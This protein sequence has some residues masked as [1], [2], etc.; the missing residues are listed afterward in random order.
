PR[1]SAEQPQLS[2]LPV[3]RHHQRTDLEPRTQ[4]GAHRSLSSPQPHKIDRSRRQVGQLSPHS[5]ACGLI[6]QHHIQLQSYLTD[7]LLKLEMLWH[8]RGSMRKWP[9]MSSLWCTR[10]EQ[11]SR[12]TERMNRSCRQFD[13]FANLC[14]PNSKSKKLLFCSRTASPGELLKLAFCSGWISNELRL[15]IRG[16]FASLK[17]LAAWHTLL[18]ALFSIRS[19]RVAIGSSGVHRMSETRINELKSAETLMLVTVAKLTDLGTLKYSCWVMKSNRAAMPL[20]LSVTHMSGSTAKCGPSLAPV[21]CTNSAQPFTLSCATKRSRGESAGAHWETWPAASE[22]SS[23][24]TKMKPFFQFRSGGKLAEIPAGRCPIAKSMQHHILIEVMWHE[25]RTLLLL[26]AL[27]ACSGSS[28]RLAVVSEAGSLADSSI[29]TTAV[30]KL[31]NGN[32]R[33]PAF[34]TSPMS[35]ELLPTADSV[36]AAQRVCRSTGLNGLVVVGSCQFVSDVLKISGSLQL[37]TVA[38]LRGL[39]RLPSVPDSAI[40]SSP[41]ATDFLRATAEAMDRVSANLVAVLHD[42]QQASATALGEEN[43]QRDVSVR[44]EWA[45]NLTQILQNSVKAQIRYCVVVC[46]PDKIPLVFEQINYFWTV[47]DTGISPRTIETLIPA[48]ESANILLIRESTVLLKEMDCSVDLG[49]VYPDCQFSKRSM[50]ELK[51]L[52]AVLS[53]ARATQSLLDSSDLGLT[54]SNA[55]CRPL[56]PWS[57]GPAVAAQLKQPSQRKCG[58]HRSDY[59]LE[60][61][62]LLSN[63]DAVAELVP[64]GRFIVENGSLVVTFEYKE[65]ELLFPNT[66]VD[67]K[68][69]RLRVCA[70]PFPPFTRYSNYTFGTASGHSVDMVNYYASHLNFSYDIFSPPDIQFGAPVEGSPYFSGCI[71]MLQRGEAEFAMPFAITNIRYQVIDY[72]EDYMFSANTI[73]V[74]RP[75]SESKLWN[76]FTPLAW[77]SWLL[78]LGM[79]VFVPIIVFV[80]ASCNPFSGWNLRISYAFA[81]EV[82]LKEYIWSVIGSFLQQGQDFYPFA[83][84]PRTVLAFWWMLTVIL[85]G[86]YTGDL[87]AKLAVTVAEYPI[88]SLEDL[89]SM[90]HYKAMVARGT[91]IYATIMLATDGPMALLRR[92]MVVVDTMTTCAETLLIKDADPYMVCISDKSSNSFYASAFCS[93]VYQATSLFNYYYQ[94]MTFPRDAYYLPAFDLLLQRGKES[95]VV[96]VVTRKYVPQSNDCG[97]SNAAAQAAAISLEGVGG[98]YIICL[99]LYVC[100]GLVLLVELLWVM[101]LGKQPLDMP[102]Y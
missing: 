19:L 12:L 69:A 21:S 95:G 64:S 79:L 13:T 42:R 62:G 52:E 76:V 58:G 59:F 16:T 73:L 88:Q 74:K 91:N 71:G 4:R 86:A 10:T 11:F 68:G 31:V 70:P 25:L 92:Q 101:W 80:L 39:C 43:R 82:W 17:L 81:D 32:W 97:G 20:R 30:D 77:D 8:S 98:A 44:R 34:K 84:S 47:I 72:S 6:L 66:F 28:V 51:A 41:L 57:A 90:P 63:P 100:G 3:C 93:Q 9:F 1:A 23:K 33:Y 99:G 38:V 75:P 24:A 7:S 26:L 61:L 2:G 85:Y 53:F 67:F 45:T 40:V 5:I 50:L 35:L 54:A 96:D 36:E 29:I 78:I 49:V 94:A 15:C 102:G 65:R 56:Q 14:L 48:N 83:M 27:H 89:V 55:S 46:E 87:T 18:R 22:Q 37:P 60:M